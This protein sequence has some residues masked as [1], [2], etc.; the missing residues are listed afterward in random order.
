MHGQYTSSTD[1][2]LIRKE[3]TFQWLWRGDLKGETESETI[4][5]KIRHYKQNVMQQIYYRQTD[6]DIKCRLCQ[7]YDKAIDHIL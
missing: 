3:D 7:Q 1:G 5:H 6:R 2:Q 4:Q